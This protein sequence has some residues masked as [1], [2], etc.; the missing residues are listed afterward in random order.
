MTGVSPRERSFPAHWV[1]YWILPVAEDECPIVNF[2]YL[3]PTEAAGYWPLHYFSAAVEGESSSSLSSV[4]R[5]SAAWIFPR[6]HEKVSEKSRRGPF[7]RGN[8]WA[9]PP[10]RPEMAAPPYFS[11]RF[12]S[13][14]G[15]GY[16]VSVFRRKWALHPLSTAIRRLLY[17]RDTGR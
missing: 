6:H 10:D 11:H 13:G 4:P 3:P 8:L 15:I 7:P 1:R 17:R 9:S 12:Y 5:D 14:M 2:S 16:N